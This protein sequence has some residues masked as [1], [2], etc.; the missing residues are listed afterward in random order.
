MHY[1]IYLWCV[2]IGMKSQFACV[3]RAVSPSGPKPEVA[4][5]KYLNHY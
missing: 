1:W 5:Q 4:S 2:S 3:V